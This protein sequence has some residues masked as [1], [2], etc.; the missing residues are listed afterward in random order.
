[1]RKFYVSILVIFIVACAA[2][3]SVQPQDFADKLTS[4]YAM[5]SAM[6]DSAVNLLNA[7]KISSAEF[8]EINAQLGTVR[9]S[10]DVVRVQSVLE[11]AQANTKLDTIR[12]GLSA[13]QSY[14]LTRDQGK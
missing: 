9:A 3:G 8:Q 11:P 10:L 12:L 5:T 14:L 4:G 6:R 1:M 2:I 7:Q 13:L